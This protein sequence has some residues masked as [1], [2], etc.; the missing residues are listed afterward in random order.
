MAS[1]ATMASSSKYANKRNA[2]NFSN[3][4]N[5]LT[6]DD[7]IKWQEKVAVGIRFNPTDEVLASH[8]LAWK[9]SGSTEGPIFSLIK[10]VDVHQLL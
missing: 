7:S 5:S 6:A 4:S 8:F 1:P 3:I 2:Y 10:E 9:L